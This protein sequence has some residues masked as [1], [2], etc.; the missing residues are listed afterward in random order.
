MTALT[1]VIPAWNEQA[2]IRAKLSDLYATE[3][4]HTKFDVLVGCD[5]CT[6]AT[7]EY[8]RAFARERGLENLQV[9]EFERAGKVSTLNRLVEMATGDVVLSTDADGQIAD[10]HALASLI[11]LFEE[12]ER[13][14]GVSCVPVFAVS[15]AESHYWR[16]EQR[17]RAFLSRRGAQYVATGMGFAFRRAC[18]EMIPLRIM[19]DDLWLPLTIL[20]RGYRLKTEETFRVRTDIFQDQRELR[21]KVRVVA[22]GMQTVAVFFRTHP[23]M[24]LTEA[25]LWLFMFKVLKWAL[26]FMA[27]GA[28]LVL[29]VLDFRVLLGT[30]GVAIL[31]MLLSERV[32]YFVLAVFVP[33]FAVIQLCFA[34]D[35]ARWQHART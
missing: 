18:F 22:G 33:V 1:V 24:L 16:L 5:G 25:F 23:G 2:A 30:V 9:Y 3:L 20:R 13:L 11:Q 12:D 21:R 15:A 35:L 26:P 17:I 10:R 29:G 31:A 19:A 6:D 14:G 34:R 7:A 28:A 32:R 27:L 4:P 8:V